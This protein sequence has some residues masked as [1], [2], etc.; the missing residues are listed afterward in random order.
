MPCDLVSSDCIA[1]Y[2]GRSE[3]VPQS[4]EYATSRCRGFLAYRC[5]LW[6]HHSYRIQS[7]TRHKVQAA[8]G[9]LA[10]EVLTH[11]S[12]AMYDFVGFFPTWIFACASHPLVRDMTSSLPQRSIPE[13]SRI[14]CLRSLVS[15][16][17]C[18]NTLLTQ[19]V[20]FSMKLEHF[21]L[22]GGDCWV[23]AIS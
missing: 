14:Y 22:L 9:I 5:S 15:L 11:K 10:A 3:L 8:H 1:L 21:S 13:A 12:G 7:A 20:V 2:P 19:F 23:L 16:S 18:C 6:S 17:C 4:S